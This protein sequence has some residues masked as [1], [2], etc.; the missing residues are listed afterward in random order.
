MS[1]TLGISDAVRALADEHFEIEPDL[2][3]VVWFRSDGEREI[4]LL[5]INRNTVATGRVE[6]FRFAPSRDT[7][8]PVHIAD[9][10]YIAPT[11]WSYSACDPIQNQTRSDS[12]STARAR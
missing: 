4:R 10:V 6:V 11:S 2:E 3:R 9:R 1:D 7:P 12:V 8:Y 5:E